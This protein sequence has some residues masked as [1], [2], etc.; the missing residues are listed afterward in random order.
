MR[1]VAAASAQPATYEPGV[2]AD[3]DETYARF[4]R[5]TTSRAHEGTKT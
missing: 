2:G 5:A 1:R 3:G 4:L